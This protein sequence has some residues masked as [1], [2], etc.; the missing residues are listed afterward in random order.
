[1]TLTADP[2][3]SNFGAINLDALLPA[4]LLSSP[5]FDAAGDRAGSNQIKVNQTKSNQC[6]HASRPLPKETYE[7]NLDNPLRRGS[8]S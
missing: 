2:P 7:A 6:A 8:Q 4:I 1:M 3:S 5:G